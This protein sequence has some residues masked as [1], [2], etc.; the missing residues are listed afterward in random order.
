MP[1]ETAAPRVDVEFRAATPADEAVVNSAFLRGLR[2]SNYTFGVAEGPFFRVARRVWMAARAEMT[3]TIA[4][5]AGSPDEV[6]G[7]CTH[8][9]NEEGTPVVAWLY[10]AK[11]WRRFGVGR[12]LLAE[13]KVLPHRKFAL[14]FAHPRPLRTFRA[15]NYQPMFSPFACW[16]WL[17]AG[18][19]AR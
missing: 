5:V 12:R 8:S 14:L 18:E 10:V 15:A 7:F 19:A 17:D 2:D 13:A 1:A 3:T 9:V 4:H 16:K 6:M 11:A